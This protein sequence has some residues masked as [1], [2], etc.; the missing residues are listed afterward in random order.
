MILWKKCFQGVSLLV[1]F[2]IICLQFHF[3][4][5]SM[6]KFKCVERN[7][8]P[9]DSNRF[10]PI[11]RLEPKVKFKCFSLES[12]LDSVSPLLA[13]CFRIVGRNPCLLSSCYRQKLAQQHCYAFHHDNTLGNHGLFHPY[14]LATV[15][16]ILFKCCPELFV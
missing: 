4:N 3:Q 16:R 10:D 12:V 14:C 2:F 5:V 9:P 6:P 15:S 7:L 13:H 8:M 1:C 11:S